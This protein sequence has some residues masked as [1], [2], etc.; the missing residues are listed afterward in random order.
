MGET[1]STIEDKQHLKHK[2]VNALV[3]VLECET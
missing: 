2:S 3:G 1:T